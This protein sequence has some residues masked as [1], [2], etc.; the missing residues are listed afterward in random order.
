MDLHAGVVDK[1][2]QAAKLAHRLLYKVGGLLILRNIDLQNDALAV[3]FL[4]YL[5]HFGR[6]WLVVRVG[7]DDGRALLRK[8]DGDGAADAAI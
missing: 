1:D 4:N 7:H 6:F 3:S 5:L 2:I 8:L